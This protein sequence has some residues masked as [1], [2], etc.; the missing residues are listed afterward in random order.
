MGKEG[1]PA[2]GEVVVEVVYVASQEGCRLLEWMK[3]CCRCIPLLC[4][5]VLKRNTSRS[6]QKIFGTRQLHAKFLL[7]FRDVG[8]RAYLLRMAHSPTYITGSLGQKHSFLQPYHIDSSNSTTAL[9]NTHIYLLD[10]RTGHAIKHGHPPHPHTPPQHPLPLR[11]PTHHKPAMLTLPTST[12][13][14]LLRLH[15]RKTVFQTTANDRDRS[16][17]NT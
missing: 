16:T 15:I 3:G 12:T 2:A 13:M 1:R 9:R 6:C 7:A 17:T 5:G 14:S 10:E 4:G 11:L 8:P